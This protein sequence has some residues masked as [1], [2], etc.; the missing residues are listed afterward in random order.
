[1]AARTG[2]FGGQTAIVT[3]GGSGI[4]RA[5]GAALLA[6]G[7]DVVLADVDGP[8]ARAAAE[9]MTAADPAA[10]GAVRGVQ[11][12]V[13]DRD[14]VQALVDETV[15]RRGRLDFMFNNA[16]IAVGGQTHEVSGAL[17]D[18]ILDVNVR[19]VV[20]GV[21]AAYPLMVRQ[22]HGHIVNTASGAGLAP[23]AL[24]VPYVATKHAVVG[25]STAL[26]PEA[27]SHGVRVSVLCPGAVD[28]PILD[29][30]PPAE[31]SMPAAS[32]MS[33]REY[34]QTMGMRL[35]PAD[36]LAD[37]ALAAV[38]RNRA[39]IVVPGNAKAIWYLQ[40]LSPGLVQAVN[41][42]AVR[43]LERKLARS[44]ADAGRHA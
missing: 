38:A 34:M 7:A 6:Q 21:L 35:M 12:D 44:A 43:R 13:C 28:T 23:A 41:R 14:A 2:G 40:R 22:G 8:K 36:T 19:G 26:R 42:I 29:D 32:T 37:R 24:V 15:S 3:G 27:A 16:G 10:L 17:W 20:N 25:L 4:G 31:L 39:V 9:E 5:M 11:L 1:M 18:H 30:L 33:G